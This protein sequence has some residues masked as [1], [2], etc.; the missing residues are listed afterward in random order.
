MITKVC[1]LIVMNPGNESICNES[2]EGGY[3]L[4]SY[5]LIIVKY[6][7]WLENF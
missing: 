4:T 6:G 5:S 7:S 3:L 2:R 1:C